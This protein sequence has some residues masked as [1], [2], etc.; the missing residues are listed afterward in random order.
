ME[1]NWKKSTALFL[2]TIALFIAGCESKYT[3]EKYFYT[4]TLD[5]GSVKIIGYN[6]QKSVDVR[7]PPVINGL[8]VT[9]IGQTAFQRKN[10][11]SVIIPDSVLEIEEWAFAEN[12]IS[13][14]VLS[15]NMTRIKN[16]TFEGNNITE[17]IIPENIRQIDYGAF[18]PKKDGVSLSKVTIGDNVMLY[19]PFQ[20]SPLQSFTGFYQS[21]VRS[22]GGTYY[23]EDNH[24]VP[25]DKTT[26][27]YSFESWWGR[28]NLINLSFLADMPL[29]ERVYLRYRGELKDI[30]GLR[31]L[32]KLKY[33]LIE[34]CNNIETLEPLSGLSNLETLELKLD[35][36]DVSHIYRIDSLK[37]LTLGLNLTVG[38]EEGIIENMELLH[39]MVNLEN[40]VLRNIKDIDLSWIALAQSLK[41]IEFS[42]NYLDDI[43]PLAK[44]PNL[45]KVTFWSDQIIED[46]RPLL[47]STSIKEINIYVNEYFN[48][49][50]L[51]GDLNALRAMFSQRGIDLVI[52]WPEP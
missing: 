1:L 37:N 17:L 12:E 9:V 31:N 5:D 14:L 46:P 7:I 41:T 48:G 30:S 38:F 18:A 39:Y 6:G 49:W 32:E 11:N 2:I 20:Q 33:I 50:E 51:A 4:K 21:G 28:G 45:I 13:K 36:I 25:E 3:N 35:R 43:T 40:L 44:A 19:N 24:W 52:K 27:I 47:E 10:L 29:I 22:K 23:I 42:L 8:P 26:P 15:N 16:N 34:N